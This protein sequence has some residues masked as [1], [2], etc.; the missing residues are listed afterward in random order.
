MNTELKHSLAGDIPTSSRRSNKTEPH[1]AAI[2]VARERWTH[3]DVVTLKRGS[4]Q[5]QF[6]SARRKGSDE[7]SIFDDFPPA[8]GSVVAQMVFG[9]CGFL[10]AARARMNGAD[11]PMLWVQGD[12][13][14]G[15]HVTGVS[16]FALNGQPVRRVKLA[17]RVVG[18]AWS[19]ANA[20]Y[21]FLAGVLPAD[22]VAS[23]GA[24]THSCF[25][26]I[27]AALQK[28]GMDFSHVARTW[29]YLDKLL[30][31]YGEFNVARTQFFQSRGV[32][33]R[34]IPAST[35]IG[36]K[37][38]FGAVLVA[39]ALAVRPKHNRVRIQEIISPLQCPATEY[40]SSFSRAVEMTFPDHRTL[41]ISGTASIAPVGRTVFANSTVKQIHLTL[42]VVEAILK[43]RGMDWQNTTRAVAYFH[44]IRALP[45]FEDCCRERGIPPLPLAPA[46]ATVCRADLWFEI[47]LDAMALMPAHDGVDIFSEPVNFNV[48][49]NPNA[50]ITI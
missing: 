17:D 12:V 6:I 10:D 2:N 8:S 22:F 42:D 41:M 46:H 9:G 32:F 31:W 26:Q 37:N 21:C 23:R 25:E 39:G 29:F 38:P 45:I 5:E 20:D 14:P 11:W 4:S 48:E 34:L 15:A 47:E 16:A 24:Q 49:D 40:R 19:D 28:V 7:L 44:D 27:E 13:C 36:A 3:G 50:L 30:D 35:G 33:D 1:P 43:S 18:S